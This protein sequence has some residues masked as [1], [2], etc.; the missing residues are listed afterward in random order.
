MVGF[1]R[2]RHDSANELEYII[3]EQ[4]KFDLNDNLGGQKFH[5]YYPIYLSDKQNEEERR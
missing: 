4:D 5:H 1:F 2:A 3:I